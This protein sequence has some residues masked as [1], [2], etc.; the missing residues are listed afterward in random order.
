MALTT[1][2]MWYVGA[3]SLASKTNTKAFADGIDR[4]QI[5]QNLQS[6]GGPIPSTC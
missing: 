5:T 1:T 4:D 2:H 6:D 3:S